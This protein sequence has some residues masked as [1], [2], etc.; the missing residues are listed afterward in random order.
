MRPM[1][2]WK[3]YFLVIYCILLIVQG[4][5]FYKEGIAGITY[6]TYA[7]FLATI[8]I[9]VHLLMDV[10]TKL[11]FLS[12]SFKGNILLS[13]NAILLTFLVI[14]GGLRASRYAKDLME[15][16]MTSI[17]YN[18]QYAEP[19]GIGWYYNWDTNGS[20]HLPL[21]GTD[22]VYNRRTNNEG[23]PDE[24]FSVQKESNEFRIIS[25]GDSF[26][27]GDGAP[28]DSTWVQLLEDILNAHYTKRS[29]TNFNA[30]V[31]GNDPYFNYMML[32]G[33]LLKYK[34]DLVIATVN[35]TDIWDILK[36][37]EMERFREDGNLA[38]NEPPWWEWFYAIS[39]IHRRFLNQFFGYDH[40]LQTPKQRE[41]AQ[42]EAVNGLVDLMERFRD[43]GQKKNFKFMVVFHPLMDET[44]KK[45][46]RFFSGIIDD[47]KEKPGIHTVDMLH[48]FIHEANMTKENMGK[49]YWLDDG[50]HTSQGYLLFAKLVKQELLRRGLLPSDSVV[51]A[52]TSQ[53]RKSPEN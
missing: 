47:L 45:N 27:E 12:Y 24:D 17:M 33:R 49:Y 6:L 14:E 41:Q 29:F 37:G 19:E 18:S 38:Y 11:N 48:Q 10:L 30:G 8:A 25:M 50:H 21:K 1:K 44:R 9:V 28:K 13:I 3:K 52:S 43:L 16:H 34:P 22:S 4:Y 26:T 23:L 42:Q 20:H 46:Y 7:L 51:T 2:K 31:I 35:R 36:R 39:Y 5:I 15:G 32:K 53:G 40:L